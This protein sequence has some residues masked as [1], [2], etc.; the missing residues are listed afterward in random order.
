MSEY[1][2]LRTYKRNR[3]VIIVKKDEDCF[4]ILENGFFQDE[5]EVSFSKLPGTLRTL[6]KKE[7]PRSRKIRLYAMGEYN[8]DKAEKNPRKVI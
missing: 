5:F 2:G 7:F 3:S 1:L 6:L 4:L 8:P